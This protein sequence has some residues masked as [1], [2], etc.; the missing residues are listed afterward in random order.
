MKGRKFQ[1]SLEPRS[2]GQVIRELNQYK[3]ELNQKAEQVRKRVAEVLAQ[4]AQSGFSMAKTDVTIRDGNRGASVNVSVDEKG[5][6]SV[7]IADGEDAVWCEFGTGV[8][9]NDAAG[10]SPHPKGSELG[11]TI[12]SY[13]KGYGKRNVWGFRENGQLVLT[14]GTPASMPMYNALMAVCEN[15]DSIVAEVFG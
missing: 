1:C 13:G 2:I 3:L 15:I 12:G 6:M 9:F 11:L 5:T 4:Y 8:F 7:V 10:S 14:R